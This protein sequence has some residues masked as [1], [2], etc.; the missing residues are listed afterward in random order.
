VEEAIAMITFGASVVDAMRR[1]MEVLLSGKISHHFQDILITI[2][3]FNNFL[4]KD[5]LVADEVGFSPAF[6]VLFFLYQY[7]H[8]TIFHLKTP[9]YVTICF[10]KIHLHFLYLS[11]DFILRRKAYGG[12]AVAQSHH[13]V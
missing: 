10:F 12:H 8:D 7:V 11:R 5:N 1:L 4:T 13:F 2:Q 9:R 6:I 3:F